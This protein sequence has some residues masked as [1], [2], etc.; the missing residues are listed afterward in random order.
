MVF[1]ITKDAARGSAKAIRTGH[2]GWDLVPLISGIGRTPGTPPPNAQFAA[3]LVLLRIIT[4]EFTLATHEE[5]MFAL[6]AVQSAPPGRIARYTGYLKALVPPSIREPLETLMKTVF[7]DPWVDGLLN[8]GRTEMLLKFLE[9][10]FSVPDDIR[11]RV[12][13]CADTEQIMIWASRVPT[14]T[15]LDEVFAKLQAMARR[16]RRAMIA[17]T[18]TADSP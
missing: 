7:K 17:K 10:R 8:Q 13:S 3:E 4:G 12:E 11:K 15:S 14:A 2:P 9:M 5:R 6:A 18:F 16:W 1:A